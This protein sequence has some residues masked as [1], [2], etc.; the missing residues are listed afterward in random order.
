MRTSGDLYC[1]SC[2]S[3]TR[4]EM[5]ADVRRR[6]AGMAEVSEVLLQVECA[7]CAQG[8]LVKPDT[9]ETVESMDD[10]KRRLKMLF[11][12]DRWSEGRNKAINDILDRAEPLIG[13]DPGAAD[14]LV[15]EAL[16][17]RRFDV[18]G[19]FLRGVLQMRRG[20][21]ADAVE[22]LRVAHRFAPESAE[23]WNNL[24]SCYVALEQTDLAEQCFVTGRKLHRDNP[25]MLLGL[26]NVA[27][28]RGEVLL[29]RKHL[30]EARRLDPGYQPARVLLASIHRRPP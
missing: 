27:L 9:L 29:A 24:G 25:K 26:A 10:S 20:A 30:E 5:A 1:A 16:R 18:R 12:D 13:R 11:L 3:V 21:W 8:L 2:G 28:L 22:T 23:L 4:Y 6:I 14:E 17:L 7:S 19:L 15:S